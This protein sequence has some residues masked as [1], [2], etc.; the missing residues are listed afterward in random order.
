M[1]EDETG[2]T[3]HSPSGSRQE[4]VSGLWLKR[5][6]YRDASVVASLVI[7]PF[8]IRSIYQDAYLLAAMQL[9]FFLYLVLSA[10]LLHTRRR[11]KLNEEFLLFAGA[12]YV[13]YNIYT[14]GA[15]AGYAAYIGCVASFLLLEQRR[16]VWYN[17]TVIPIL[18][19]LLGILVDVGVAARAFAT[20]TLVAAL[21]YILTSRLETRNRQLFARTQELEQATVAKSEFLAN[22]SHE[23]RTPLTTVAGYSENMLNDASLTTEKRDQ[24]EAVVVSV[25]HL[26]A[27]IDD[28]LDLSKIEAGH[29]R[30]NM[31]EV[32]LAPLVASLVFTQ[33]EAARA[34]GLDFVLTVD[35]PLP[36]HFS[37]DPVRLNQ[38]LYNLL[39]N[40]IKFTSS[41]FVELAI[42]HDPSSSMLLF[43]V[44]DSGIGV[45]AKYRAQLFQ[46]FSQEDSS[47]TRDYRGA[48]L[49]LYISQRLAELL[50]GHIEYIPREQGS[51]FQLS[52][53]LATLTDEWN[54]DEGSFR[55]TRHFNVEPQIQFSGQV[56]IAEDS[57]V[58][59]LLIKLLVEKCG[60]QAVVVSNGQE[61][62][63]YVQSNVVDFVLMDLQMPV[64]SGVEAA[65]AIRVF[66][67]RIPIFAL[68]ADVLRNELKSRKM[69]S[70]TGVLAK[71]I[72]TGLL[73]ST[74]ARFLPAKPNSD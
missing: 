48:G 65:D 7:L 70:F 37:M 59:Q 33:E 28:I 69:A 42:S 10:F 19:I 14:S 9:F 56:L 47:I 44:I 30:V 16:A 2:K 67:T 17:V 35:M 40:A 29:L 8:C 26:A 12:L 68:S 51:I 11:D 13:F 20:L 41:G 57:A 39:G 62:V 27:L 71:P 63:N 58:N 22:M 5:S 46:Q 72:D 25:R 52:L 32:E 45:E 74:F 3:Q 43:R 66:N 21:A 31:R 60:L 24:L 38:I 18:A 4:N 53:Q 61:A 15:V 6:L 49:G 1:P 23:M 73:H 50:N 36:R 34:K 55:E 64:M 54:E